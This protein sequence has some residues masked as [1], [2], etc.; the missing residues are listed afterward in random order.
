MVQ[1]DEITHTRAANKKKANIPR[2]AT[3]E[4]VLTPRAA[5]AKNRR[6]D[7]ATGLPSAQYVTSL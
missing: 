7:T 5:T 4:P 6:N 1:P 2:M 3:N